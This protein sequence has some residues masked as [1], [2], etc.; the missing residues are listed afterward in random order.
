MK[1]NHMGTDPANPSPRE[2]S[3][4]NQTRFNGPLPLFGYAPLAP[5]VRFQRPIRALWRLRRTQPSRKM[6]IATQWPRVLVRRLSKRWIACLRRRTIAAR[7]FGSAP[8]ALRQ[9]IHPPPAMLLTMNSSSPSRMAAGSGSTWGSVALT[10][11]LAQV[12]C[13]IVR[14]GSFEYCRGPLRP[15]R[16]EFFCASI[17]AHAQLATRPCE[18]VKT[19][20]F[21]VP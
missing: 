11:S 14:Q 3:L 19:G 8:S 1:G 16:G 18:Y 15:V 21:C 13:G 9:P 5:Y 12:S 20:R 4:S 2:L 7:G 17:V 10:G 6:E